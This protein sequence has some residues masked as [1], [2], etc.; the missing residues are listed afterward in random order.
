MISCQAVNTSYCLP[1]TMNTGSSPH[2]GVSIWVLVLALRALIHHP[3]LPMISSTRSDV[4]T[5]MHSLVL[6]W[7]SGTAWH[8]CPFR[9][10]LCSALWWCWAAGSSAQLG[11]L[12][13][14]PWPPQIWSPGCLGWCWGVE[15]LQGSV[16]R[17]LRDA[18]PTPTPL[19][20]QLP[21]LHHHRHRVWGL[22]LPQMQEAELIKSQ[23]KGT[24]L[25]L[26]TLV[27]LLPLKPHSYPKPYFF[28]SFQIPLD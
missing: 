28:P 22:R 4:S 18:I 11:L 13:G 10:W 27:F 16:C 12:S 6:C 26:H 3:W 19:P 25:F 17:L 7:P 8:L 5:G 23:L 1:V 20:F 24:L 9:A 2:T 15:R 21:V 14:R